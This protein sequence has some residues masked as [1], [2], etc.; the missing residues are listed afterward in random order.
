MMMKVCHLRTQW[1]TVP[2]GGRRRRITCTNVHSKAEYQQTQRAGHRSS[3]TGASQSKCFITLYLT[4]MKIAYCP[5]EHDRQTL[6]KCF[7]ILLHCIPLYSPKTHNNEAVEIKLADIWSF[8]HA[9]AFFM[10]VFGFICFI[11]HFKRGIWSFM[12]VRWSIFC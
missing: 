11:S 3:S 9:A 7:H 10:T 4:M 1:A 6:P 12:F 2:M 8:F 5:F